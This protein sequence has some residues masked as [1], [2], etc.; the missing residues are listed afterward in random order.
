MNNNWYKKEKPLLGLTGLGGGVDGLAVVGAAT[1]T[2]ID[3][4]FSTYVYEGDSAG[5]RDITNNIDVSGKGGIV[6]IKSRSSGLDYHI[7]NTDSGLNKYMVT[8]SAAAESTIGGGDSNYNNT[9]KS[10]NAD[11]FSLGSSNIVNGS[12]D[13]V[14]WTFRKQEKFFDMVT[15]TGNGS[16]R[17]ISHSLGS[18]PGV[19]I[20]KRTDDS[21]NWFVYHANAPSPTTSYLK[22]NNSSASQSDGSGVIWNS[23]APTS[24]VF[25]V[26]TDGG[27]NGSGGTYVA[28]LFAHNNSDGP[29]GEGSD[30]DAINCG[31]YSGN[32]S[33]NGPTIN[34]GW[35]PQWVL[36][37]RTNTS[38]HWALFDAMRGITTDNDARLEASD[39]GTENTGFDWIELTSKGFQLKKDDAGVNASGSTYVYMAIRM[40]DGVVG[41]P[42]EAGTDAFAMD[43]GNSSGTIPNYDSTFPVDF[44]WSKKYN[45]S[46]GWYTGARKTNYQYL[47]TD[48]SSQ[49]A[50]AGASN[51][52][53]DSN[54]GWQS[55]N[56]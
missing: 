23:T 35:E 25:S 33:I 2:Y 37:K 32:G 51:W 21:D 1:K 15:Y 12:D 56:K 28:Y 41:K 47:Q 29:F 40:A 7:F 3:D 43:Y 26:G 4:V 46:G 53:W 44:A 30:K 14:S 48:L 45:G 22:L 55:D 34:I 13:F 39:S 42:A 18:V 52:T 49:Q 5:N 16:N 24:T 36:I 54:L 17:T 11:G 8:N 38:E 10:F 27:V 6:W 9:L 19:M 31:T 20:I 50:S